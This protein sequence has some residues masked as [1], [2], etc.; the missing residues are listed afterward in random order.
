ML[1]VTRRRVALLPEQERDAYT[2]FVRGCFGAADLSEGL[3]AAAGSRRS[4]ALTS[5]LGI[6]PNARPPDVSLHQWVGL[7]SSLRD[8][9]P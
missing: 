8:L 9:E 6:A 7:Y 3:R 2:S 4:A 5:E 1:T